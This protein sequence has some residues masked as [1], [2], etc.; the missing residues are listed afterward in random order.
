M[1]EQLHYW[2]DEHHS[3]RRTFEGPVEKG[4]YKYLPG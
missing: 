4:E 1:T 3:D 2:G